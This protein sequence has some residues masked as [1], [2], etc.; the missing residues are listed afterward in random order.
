[1]CWNWSPLVIPTV[2]GVVDLVSRPDRERPAQEEAGGP[3]LRS[4]INSEVGVD[5]S[6]RGSV[7]IVLILHL[8]HRPISK[9]GCQQREAHHRRDHFQKRRCPSV[10]LRRRM[11]RRRSKTE[12]WATLYGFNL[13]VRVLGEFCGLKDSIR[14]ITTIFPLPPIC[15]LY[16]F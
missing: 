9:G 6:E 13:V 16:S 3:L 11:W 7:A 14:L 15:N 2:R 10:E 1:M 5:D 8:N 4:P 12:V